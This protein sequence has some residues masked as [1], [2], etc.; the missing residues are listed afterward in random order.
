MTSGGNNFDDFPENQ[1]PKF[2][3][4]HRSLRVLISFGETASPA[5][6]L[7]HCWMNTGSQGYTYHFAEVE[8]CPVRLNLRQCVRRN[9]WLAVFTN[10]QRSRM[11]RSCFNAAVNVAE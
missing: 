4:Y 5:F 9:I 1:L 6:L 11:T 2:V 7:D 3:Q 8:A 10:W